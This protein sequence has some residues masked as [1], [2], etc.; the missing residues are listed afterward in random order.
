MITMG[1]DFD[2]DPL[3]FYNETAAVRIGLR[4]RKIRNAKGLSQAELG[5]AVGLSADR[6]QKY[7][8]GFRKPKAD[9]LK[10][11]YLNMLR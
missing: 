1:K 2:R 10:K 7:E 11:A 8:N 5:A 9:M 6:I 3:D 4:I